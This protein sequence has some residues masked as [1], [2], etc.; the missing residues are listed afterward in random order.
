MDRNGR[1]AVTITVNVLMEWLESTSVHKGM[2]CINVFK[3][4][5]IVDLIMLV[6]RFCIASLVI[7]NCIGI[8]KSVIQV[9]GPQAIV[10]VLSC[11]VRFPKI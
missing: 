8:Q 2:V 1:M 11:F 5:T 6:M 3:N 10:F 9:I 7:V 4:S